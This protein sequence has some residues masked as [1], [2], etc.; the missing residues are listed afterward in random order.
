[1]NPINLSV[2]QSFSVDRSVSLHLICVCLSIKQNLPASNPSVHWPYSKTLNKLVII[3]TWTKKT[4]TFLFG[5]MECNCISWDHELYL[6]VYLSATVTAQQIEINY[7]G[8][9]MKHLPNVWLK[10]SFR[11]DM[12]TISLFQ[13]EWL[14]ST[15]LN[16]AMSLVL[17]SP[18]LLNKALFTAK[19]D[20]VVTKRKGRKFF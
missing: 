9:Y 11:M 4:V 10:H 15:T 8:I 20:M 17:L 2:C 5:L 1:M 19:P 13:L 18:R 14:C 16:Y 6:S 7:K 3:K 12:R